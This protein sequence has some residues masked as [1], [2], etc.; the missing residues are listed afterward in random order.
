[1]NSGLSSKN[2]CKMDGKEICKVTQTLQPPVRKFASEDISATRNS[3]A[4]L[5]RMS[6]EL[7]E[8][9]EEAA[10]PS[11]DGH[12]I[13]TSILALQLQAAQIQPFFRWLIEKARPTTPSL[14]LVPPPHPT[15]EKSESPSTA[16]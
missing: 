7:G 1:M 16:T 11:S 12:L 2:L 9:M 10:E 6:G 4:A 5:K 3:A 13:S 8:R 15:R 14:L